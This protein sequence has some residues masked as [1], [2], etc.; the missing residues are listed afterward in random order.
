MADLKLY[1]IADLREWLENNRPAE[2]LS[3]RVITPTRAWAIVHNSYVKDEDA[4]VAAI[5]EDGEL[6]AYT[7]SFPDMLG[8]KRIWW[9]TTLWCESEYQGKGY[10]L[11]V[12]GNLVE[13][14]EPEMSFDL[15]GAAET[16]EIMRFLRYKIA[17]TPQY[18]YEAKSI[19]ENVVRGKISA[20]MEKI[21]RTF[22]ARKNALRR[23]ISKTKYQLRYINYIDDAT[24]EFIQKHAKQQDEFKHTQSF[25]NWV[26]T[27]PICIET[28]LINQVNSRCAFPAIERVSKRYAVQVLE[29]EKIKAF[30]I[31]KNTEGAIE[32]QFLYYDDDYAEQT[33]C[34]IAEH[35]LVFKSKGLITT[36]KKLSEFIRPYRM[37]SKCRIYNKSFAYPESY[38]YNGEKQLQMG[39]GDN[40]A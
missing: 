30:Y 13:A 11:I 27:Y 23:R 16:Q 14:H 37:F 39:D 2:G 18:Q 32:V 36:D 38:E 4:I 22:M 7:A 8:G 9:L 21:I 25:Y 10:G 26:L 20:I 15:D 6:A 35:V 33:Y 24:Y 3:E 1:T 40:F 34:S 5:F 28:P 19:D 31:I 17:Y 12:V 29:D